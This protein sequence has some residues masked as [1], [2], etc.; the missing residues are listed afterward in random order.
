LR[1]VGD[2]PRHRPRARDR[3]KSLV[4]VRVVPPL[5]CCSQW[6]AFPG[7]LNA[8]RNTSGLSVVFDR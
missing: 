3:G 1:V 4:H 6:L 2:S 7:A 8:T 5:T